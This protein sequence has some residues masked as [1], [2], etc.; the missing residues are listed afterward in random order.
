MDRTEE[1]APQTQGEHEY[2]LQLNTYYRG[3]CAKHSKHG[4]DE[5]SI[6]GR[7]RRYQKN[8]GLV[9]ENKG[10]G[11]GQKG[12]DAHQEK[13]RRNNESFFLPSLPKRAAVYV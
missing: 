11:L 2:L 10:I 4:E 6:E 1:G 13:D 7:R 8:A 9:L 12:S 3:L 5:A